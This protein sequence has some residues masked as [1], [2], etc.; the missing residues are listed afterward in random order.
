MTSPTPIGPPAQTPHIIIPHTFSLSYPPPPPPAQAAQA[1]RNHHK[2]KKNQK[3]Y[4]TTAHSSP[5]VRPRRV[6]QSPPASPCH[7]R[8]RLAPSSGPPPSG[9]PPQPCGTAAPVRCPPS[10][11]ST[12]RDVCHDCLEEAG[13]GGWHS[14]MSYCAFALFVIPDQSVQ[15][16]PRPCRTQKCLDGCENTDIFFFCPWASHN[17][18]N[19]FKHD[20]YYF[21]YAINKCPPILVKQYGSRHPAVLLCCLRPMV[22]ERQWLIGYVLYT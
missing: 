22:R 21:E 10:T 12:F 6:A 18:F 16:T 8:P 17:R 3:H 5:P 9:C 4:D 2:K 15:L 14:W 11:S 19:F 7:P 13:R 1:A 20:M